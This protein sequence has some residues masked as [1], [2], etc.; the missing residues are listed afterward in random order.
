MIIGAIFQQIVDHQICVC[1]RKRPM[2]KKGMK[3]AK[4]DLFLEKSKNKPAETTN[5]TCVVRF[6]GRFPEFSYAR[7]LELGF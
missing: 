7:V 3:D 6:S 2:S 5:R 4:Y 1:V